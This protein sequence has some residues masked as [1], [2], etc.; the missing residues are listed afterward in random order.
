M[1]TDICAVTTAIANSTRDTIDNQNRNARAILDVL[2]QDYIRTL[3][4]ENQSLKLSRVG[5]G[6]GRGRA[7]RKKP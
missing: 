4:S 3:E 1:A 7:G 5:Q 2:N 6:T